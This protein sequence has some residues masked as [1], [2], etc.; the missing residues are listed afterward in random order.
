VRRLDWFALTHAD[1]DHA[2][3]AA[4]VIADLRPSRIL[5]GIAMPRQ[6]ERVRLVE[7][8]TSTGASVEALRAGGSIMI[9]GVL[10]DVLHPPNPEWERQSVRN[11]DSLVIDVRF[12]AVSIL[13]MGDA[14]EPV[15]SAVAA[16]LA[17]A[18]LRVLKVGHHGSRTSTSQALLAAARP[19]AALISAGRANMY[20][21]P[22][23]LV[24]ARLHGSKTPVFRT[25]QDGQIDV[26]T[27]GR[28]VGIATRAGRRWAITAR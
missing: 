15:E 20:G 25:D 16:R 21:H 14:G 7:A 1:V 23:P 5:E 9:D 22:S 10:L 18:T 13:L 26:I 28:T 27:D 24:I 19:D 8:A 17:P 12:G 2:G 11:D 4:A 3:G 6:H